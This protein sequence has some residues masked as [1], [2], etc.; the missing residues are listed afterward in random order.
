MSAS[1]TRRYESPLRERQ[2]QQTRELILDSLTE[3]LQDHRVDEI[4]TRELASAAGVSERTVYRH[5][6]DRDALVAGLGSRIN[7][8][9]P[10]PAM[11]V[12]SIDDLKAAVVEFMA[13]ME[14]NRVL[15]RADALFNADPRRFAEPTKANS[16][17]FHQV[18]VDARPELD[19]R[20]QLRLSAALRCMFSAQGWLRMREEYDIP[21]DESGPMVAWVI[22]AIFNEIDRGN[23][24]PR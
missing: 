5:F 21:G 22:D 12:N 17:R 13:V 1:L 8:L 4:S 24:P 2:A 23:P 16:A 18:V 11:A 7:Q 15:A 14:A 3:L 9:G 6:P 19:E 10:D 20:V